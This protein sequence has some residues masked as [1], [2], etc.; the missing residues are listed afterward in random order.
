[1]SNS[2]GYSGEGYGA[3][4]YG[5]GGYGGG[6]G[7]DP[8]GPAGP[9]PGNP[10]PPF[11]GPPYGGGLPPYGPTGP[12]G[13]HGPAGSPGGRDRRV[14]AVVVVVALLITG[15]V[16]ALVLSLNGDDKGNEAGKTTS[17]PSAT[18]GT[19]APP[20]TSA[21][22]V[23]ST[24]HASEP[25][26]STEP[27][28]TAPATTPEPSDSHDSVAVQ[29]VP[30]SPGDCVLFE[31]T[32]T[33]VDKVACTSAHDGQH[34]RNVDLP[35][36]TWPGE[37]A[38]DTKASAACKPVVEPVI[39]RQPQADELTWLYIYPKESGW[40]GGDREIQCLVSYLDETKKLDAP[41]R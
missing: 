16:I 7:G 31:T 4:G 17:T 30:L 18:R 36:E 32:G 5:G 25:E 10:P 22:P 27:P 39:E 34:V 6:A 21:P 20:T 35:D 41:L 2:G 28:G 33:G 12:N 8:G 3:G 29:K 23:T 13:P 38:M 19:T 9:P 15:G 1:M 40:L 26:P 11:G 24:P 37:A 14:V